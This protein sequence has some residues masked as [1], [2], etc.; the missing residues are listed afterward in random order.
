MTTKAPVPADERTRGFS[1]RDIWFGAR[2]R[3]YRPLA[4]GTTVTLLTIA[5]VRLIVVHA[6]NPHYLA[7]DLLKGYLVGAQRFLD[8]GSPYLPEQIAGPWSLDVHSFIHPPS[9]MLL[10]VP[11]LWLPILVWWIVPL[12]LT[13]LVLWRLQ[14]APWTWPVMALC[15]CWPRSTGALLTG[16]SDIWAM[17]F[18]AAGAIWGWPVVLLLIKPTF[19]P[20]AVVGARQRSTWLAGSVT[21]GAVALTA[22]LWLDF[23]TVIGNVGLGYSYSLLN[24]PLVAI[25]FVAWIGRRRPRAAG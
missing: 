3:W 23:V 16:N 18:V 13:G 7:S 21:L 9:A 25:P 14:P 6:E 8:T 19:A 1:A 2:S 15:L 5:A 10:F 17:S 11:F 12:G 4:F 22:P 24:L 20:L